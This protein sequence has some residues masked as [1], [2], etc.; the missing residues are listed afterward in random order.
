MNVTLKSQWLEQTMSLHL[1][2]SLTERWA[3][4]V[5]D[6]ESLGYLCPNSTPEH[7]K[8]EG[9][10]CHFYSLWKNLPRDQTHN[11]TSLK[12]D[13]QPQDPLS[14]QIFMQK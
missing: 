14:P 3:A 11:R 2:L 8:Q 13:R 9:N 5:H 4:V 7:P 10:G 6:R 12:A 1:T